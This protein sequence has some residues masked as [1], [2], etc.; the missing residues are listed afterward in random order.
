MRYL[1][2]TLQEFREE[3][4]KLFDQK[5]DE[6]FNRVFGGTK[7]RKNEGAEESLMTTN[8]V[9]A[10]FDISRTTLNNWI[11]QDKIMSIKKGNQRFFDRAYIERYKKVNFSFNERLP[12][13]LSKHV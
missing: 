1:P 2:M 4:T 11:R 6:F 5:A 12:T 8:E 10:Y 13:Y 7:P 3:F 9:T